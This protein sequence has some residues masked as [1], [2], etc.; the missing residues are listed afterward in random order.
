MVVIVQ[1][2][3]LVKKNGQKLDAVFIVSATKTAYKA[4]KRVL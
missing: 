3:I 1:K 2:F 4:Y